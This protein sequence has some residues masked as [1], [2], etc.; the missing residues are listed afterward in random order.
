MC[1]C[2]VVQLRLTLCNPFGLKSARL[3]CPW[4]YPS[5]N[6]GVGC[7]FLLQGVFLAQWW[8]THL[9]HCMR[10]P[11]CG[12]IREAQI[13]GEYAFKEH[14]LEEGQTVSL[15]RTPAGAALD[16]QPS[17]HWTWR[18]S[19]RPLSQA[20]LG[21]WIPEGCYTQNPGSFLWDSGICRGFPGGTSGKEPVCRRRRRKRHRFDPWVG[22]SPWRRA[23]QPT[24]VFLAWRIPWAKEPG[25]LRSIE[26]QKVGHDW[27]DLAR[28]HTRYL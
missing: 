15:P 20:Q 21:N 4:S 14:L 23:W 18:E 24:P 6:T 12:A 2:S 7:H 26:S 16:H 10:I 3:L 28:T 19:S 27:N 8:N 17:T 11:Y 5:K 1:F 25:R 13:G 9:L 22:K